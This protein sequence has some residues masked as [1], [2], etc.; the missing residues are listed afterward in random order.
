MIL[1]VC[2]YYMICNVTYVVCRYSM[3]NGLIDSRE[4]RRVKAAGPS[5]SSRAASRQRSRQGVV[6]DARLQE[7]IAQ[8]DAYYQNW[9]ASQQEKMSQHYTYVLQ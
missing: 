1:F 7:V 5:W 9:F 8:L 6:K 2:I 3:L 4:V